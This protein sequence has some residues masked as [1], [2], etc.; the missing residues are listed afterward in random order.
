MQPYF[1][2]YIGYWQLIAEVDRFVL[3][4]NI[5]YTK[6]GWINRNRFLRNGNPCSFTIPLR[7]GSDV[8][9][10]RDRW[11]AETFERDKLLRQWSGAY[12]AA[13]FFQQGMELLSPIVLWQ[14]SSLFEYLR[15]SVVSLSKALGISTAIMTSSAIP[16]DHSLRAE[17]RVIAIC[18]ALGAGTYVNPIG[19]VG[20]YEDATFAAEGIALRFHSMR[21]IRYDQGGVVWVPHLSI[22]DVLMYNGPERVRALLGEYDELTPAAART[23][24]APDHEPVGE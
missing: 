6:K 2:P 7:Q 18:R 5:E 14:T 17:R 13:P 19:G 4:D 21:A 10:V 12:R 24:V 15:N 20:L 8:L 9:D 22:V 3:Y 11:I 16:A 23:C 1:L